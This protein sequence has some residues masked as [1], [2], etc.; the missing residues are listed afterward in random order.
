MD[1]DSRQHS[2]DKPGENEMKPKV[3]GEAAG[4]RA[5]VMGHSG[6]TVKVSHLFG[7]IIGGG[8]KRPGVTSV[9]SRSERLNVSGVTDC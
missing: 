6:T 2:A 5:G 4:Q 9:T 3:S 1:T 8:Y 7:D